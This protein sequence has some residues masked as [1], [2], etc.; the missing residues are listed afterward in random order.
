MTA[1]EMLEAEEQKRMI[2]ARQ[3]CK[4]K[5]C[6]RIMTLPQ[7]AHRIPKR[8]CYLK[9]YGREVIHHRFNLVA[10]CCLRCNAAVL[11][12][13]ATHPIEAGQL[14]K[15]IREDLKNGLHG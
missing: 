11:L 3:G 2:I 12:D 5:V 8:K 14:I 1:A 6:G 10:V 15:Q 9:K 4:C 13:P 7:I